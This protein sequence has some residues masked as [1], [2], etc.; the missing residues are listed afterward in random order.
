MESLVFKEDIFQSYINQA[1]K[2]KKPIF[3]YYCTSIPLELL[4]SGGILPVRIRGVGATDTSLADSVV[5]KYNCPFIRCT[6]NLAL[7]HKFDYLSGLLITNNCDHC[8]R[9]YDVWN[10]K[11]IEDKKKFFLGYI[12]NPHKVSENARKWI[13]DEY[14][15]FK[16]KLE[17]FI[18]RKITNEQLRESI[19]KFNEARQVLFQLHELRA[20]S[21]PRLT[22]K[23]F[24]GAAIAYSQMPVEEFIPQA[25]ELLERAQS[26]APIEKY[27][28][29]LMLIGS[30]LDSPAFYDIFEEYNSTVVSDELCFG[31]RNCD[32]L[33]DE[34]GDPLKTLSKFYYEECRCPKM[35]DQFHV[36]LEGILE[37][38]KKHEITGV[39]L[40]RIEFCD[41][42][43]VANAMLK[44]KLEKEYNIPVLNIDKEYLPGDVARLKTRVE[45]FIERIER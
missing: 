19:K 3:G 7:Q 15:M 30:V 31:L 17:E 21:K 5:S 37:Q 23:E 8:R 40:Q 36:R 12:S 14:N 32:R 10:Y 4:D 2:D 42:H 13:N 34:K 22:S 39:V 38:V 33:V 29:R 26:R 16:E 6:L 41:L 1:Q 9:M 44:N 35:M 24:Y 43:G 25:A 18:G 28:S 45:A 20:E 11:I 27:Q